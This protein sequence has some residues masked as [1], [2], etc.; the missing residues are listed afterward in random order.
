ME[1]QHHLRMVAA[2]MIPANAELGL[3]G[4]NDSPIFADILEAAAP[5][6]AGV[7]LALR[8]LDETSG[9]NFAALDAGSQAAMAEKFRIDHPNQFILLVSIV[10]RCYYR[11]DRVMRWLSMEPRPP[12]PLGFELKQGDWSLLDPVRAR[13]R[14]YREV[15]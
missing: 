5:D 6:G 11:D 14:L 15:P 8:F 2:S 3:P 4:A 12:F 10:V 13:P 9:G 7:R 1:E